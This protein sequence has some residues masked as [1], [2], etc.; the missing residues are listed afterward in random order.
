VAF[1]YDI[2]TTPSKNNG[3]LG[4]TL[5]QIERCRKR[6]LYVASRT[7]DFSHDLLIGLF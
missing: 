5:T 2:Y 1:T 6:I 7:Q 3:V 4:A